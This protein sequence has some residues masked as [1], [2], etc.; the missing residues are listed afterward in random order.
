MAWNNVSPL[1]LFISIISLLFGSPV[2]SNGDKDG[3]FGYSSG[4]NGPENWGNLNENWT[5]CKTG[6]LQSPID[7][8][9]SRAVIR[10]TLGNIVR[11]YRAQNATIINRGH[12]IMV[13]WSKSP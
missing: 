9:S 3:E 13:S 2:F 7:L 5:T 1:F 4:P 11:K 10:S 12:D 6:K 8:L